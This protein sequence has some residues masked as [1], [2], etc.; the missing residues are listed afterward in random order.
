MS[1]S[2]ADQPGSRPGPGRVVD[3]SEPASRTPAAPRCSCAPQR[4]VGSLVTT[5]STL[6]PA[7]GSPPLARSASPPADRDLDRSPA[8]CEAQTS[9]P[10]CRPAVAAGWRRRMS[11]GSDQPPASGP[12]PDLGGQRARGYE[13]RRHPAHGE[14]I[15]ELSGAQ[16]P[17][18][19]EARALRP[20]RFAVDRSCPRPVPRSRPQCLRQA[21]RS[22][23]REAGR[24][25]RVPFG[26]C[27]Q[28]V[29]RAGQRQLQHRN[30]ARIGP[31]QS[32]VAR[33][34]RR[35][36]SERP[37]GHGGD[38]RGRRARATRPIDRRTRHVARARPPSSATEIRSLPATRRAS[39][40]MFGPPCSRAFA[41]RL[42][43][44]WEMRTG[45]PSSG[46][47]PARHRSTSEP[48]A[49][50]ARARHLPTAP[51]ASSCAETSRG[52]SPVLPLISRS[53]L[54]ESRDREL[55]RV[56]ETEPK[57]TGGRIA[58][59]CS[60]RRSSWRARFR[61]TR[62]CLARQPCIA[63]PASARRPA[64]TRQAPPS[65]LSLVNQP[66]SDAP[67][68]D[69]EA[70]VLGVELSAQAAGMRVERRVR[71]RER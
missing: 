7:G 47:Q 71:P 66:V 26:S 16:R 18:H 17:A 14:R 41:I 29:T 40:I 43:R 23:Q 4:C 45:S 8:G 10:A 3:G 5:T 22:R 64:A 30:R 65:F 58:S 70:A 1:A 20:E 46:A 69:D 21:P 59:S 35:R 53:S 44:A 36:P 62:L 34:G 27:R 56:R 49:C 24:C 42:S 63:R 13:P 57:C 15:G 38:C 67:A 55:Q 37:R 60:G 68:V 33:G 25:Q 31:P 48:P 52:A 51:P 2:V 39:T 19:A 12:E 32:E 6:E 9:E 28:R 54:R 50:L 61:A 11:Q